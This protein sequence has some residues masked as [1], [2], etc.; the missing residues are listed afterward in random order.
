MKNREGFYLSPSGDLIIELAV[1][2]NSHYFVLRHS[3][4]AAWDGV[5]IHKDDCRIL[6]EWTKL[7]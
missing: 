2:D 6:D 7:E 1:L 5:I 4:L 3:M